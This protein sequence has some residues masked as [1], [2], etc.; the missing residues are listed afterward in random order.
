MGRLRLKCLRT[1]FLRHFSR[2]RGTQNNAHAVPRDAIFVE[3]TLCSHGSSLE[4]PAHDESS[5]SGDAQAVL[6]PIWNFSSVSDRN[7]TSRSPA[8]PGAWY[9]RFVGNREQALGQRAP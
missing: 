6:S 8:M 7:K 2:G 4:I 9:F 1:I 3:A 5:K